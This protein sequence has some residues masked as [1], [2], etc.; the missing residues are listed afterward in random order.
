V[1]D[2]LKKLGFEVI[3]GEDLDL[4]GLGRAIGRFAGRVE[5]ADVA[6]VYFAGHGATFGDT[7]YVVPIDAEFA[8]PTEVVHELVPVETL[9]GDLRQAKGV[10]IAILD[11]C[12]DN[13]AER[14]LKQHA[15]AMRGSGEM[16]RGLG[17]M[18]NASGLICGV[19][20]SVRGH[21]GG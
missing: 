7:S 17:P 9:I 16:T 15:E 10:R 6:I 2:A 1:R 5:N 18:K 14:E 20:D 11:A 8:S 4:K 3:Y 21:G 13:V 12:R 19:C